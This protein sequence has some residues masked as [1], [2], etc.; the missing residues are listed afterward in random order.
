[1][2][3]GGSGRLAILVLIFPIWS[4]SVITRRR[5]P[6]WTGYEKVLTDIT[7]APPAPDGS[8]IRYPPDA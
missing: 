2:F 8:H 4:P 5:R 1:M 3:N 6:G 7:I